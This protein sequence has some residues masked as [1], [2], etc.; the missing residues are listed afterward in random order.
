MRAIADTHALIWWL[1][2]SPK[3]PERWREA[4]DDAANDIRISAVTLYEVR[5]KATLEKLPGAPRIVAALEQ[6]VR[7]GD[8]LVLAITGDHAAVAG[9]LPPVHRDPFDRLLAGQAIVEG[10]EI[11]SKD[12]K[13]SALGARRLW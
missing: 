11:V 7:D 8:T 5:W 9:S 13:L 10:M 4:F 2:D 1:Q 6:I 12:E 3:L